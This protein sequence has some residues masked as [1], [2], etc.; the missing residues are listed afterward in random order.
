MLAT[1]K[2]GG[3]AAGRRN[4]RV[5]LVLERLTGRSQERDYQSPAMLQGIERE[6]E[7]LAQY[8][9][10]TGELVERIG[11]VAHATLMAGGSPDGVVG[12]GLV[13]AKCPLPAT[14]LDTLKTGI[15]PGD[16]LKQIQHL[17][18]VMGAPWC[19]WLSY[20]P[21]FPASLR[22]KLVRVTM[23][24]AERDSHELLVRQFLRE[25]QDELDSVRQLQGE[26]DVCLV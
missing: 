21:D 18:W 2:S 10:V 11:F 22:V 25:V 4:Y 1:L 15:V 5:Q 16:Y 23:S 13:E 6:A 7:A 20:N 9:A 8:E 17:L 26:R 3:E 12:D 24:Q 19:D 14:H